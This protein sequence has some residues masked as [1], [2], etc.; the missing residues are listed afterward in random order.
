[1]SPNHIHDRDHDVMPA[2]L[3][4]V[5]SVSL[6]IS[7]VQHAQSPIGAEGEAAN[8]ALTAGNIHATGVLV[9]SACASVLLKPVHTACQTC[10]REESEQVTTFGKVQCEKEE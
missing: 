8:V 1:M 6:C 4:A 9:P 10:T 3:S 2:N 5:T 7:R